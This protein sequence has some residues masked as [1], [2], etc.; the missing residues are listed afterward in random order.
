[1]SR[2]FSVVIG[3]ILVFSA[4]AQGADKA[5]SG[6]K[7]YTLQPWLLGL[8]AVVVFLFIVFILLIVNRMWCKKEKQRS[9]EENPKEERVE[10]NAYEN[11]AMEKDDDDEEKGKKKEQNKK[12][13]K[14]EEDEKEDS[15]IT[16]M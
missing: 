11:K 4:M 13:A 12:E 16:A 10:I 7:S 15:K 14:W 5:S 6:G 2:F 3:I 8:T 9:N 1:M